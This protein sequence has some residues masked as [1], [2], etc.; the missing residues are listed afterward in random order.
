MPLSDWD[1]A[2]IEEFRTYI[3]SMVSG[4]ERYG[5]AQRADAADDSE[6]ASRFA[7]GSYGAV[8]MAIHP[9]G[10]QV[11]VGFLTT[12]KARDEEIEQGI[13]EAGETVSQFVGLGFHDAGLGWYDP[14]V[15]RYRDDRGFHFTTAFQLDELDALA[16]PEIRDWVLR[17]L[18]G[19]VI[20]FGTYA[21]D[22]VF[23]EMDED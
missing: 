2:T 4:D 5:P 22:E 21:V 16:T 17:M 20:A 23:E 7:L 12:D 18:E 6:F 3:E 11:R 19:Y 1:A 14:P 15:E 9:S 8:E 10:P 13:Q